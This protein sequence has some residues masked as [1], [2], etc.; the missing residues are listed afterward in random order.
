MYILAQE[1]VVHEQVERYCPQRRI[2]RTV[3]LLLKM[4]SYQEDN[5]TYSN[6]KLCLARLFASLQSS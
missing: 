5:K 3:W 2:T 4:T 6:Q 1:I